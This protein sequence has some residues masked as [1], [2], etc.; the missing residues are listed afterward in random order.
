V[1]VCLVVLFPGCFHNKNI[2][3]GLYVTVCLIVLFPGCVT[4]LGLPLEQL[5]QVYGW[6]CVGY[7]NAVCGVF[8]AI[9]FAPLWFKSSK[10][11]KDQ[12][13]KD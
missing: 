10:A 4:Y 3:Y 1:T 2:L 12:K 8:A 13:T 9:I 7:V 11:P 6:G 5:A